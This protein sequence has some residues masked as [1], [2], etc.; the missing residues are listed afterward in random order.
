M[1]SSLT[2]TSA[3]MASSAP[4][5]SAPVL[6]H[7]QRWLLAALVALTAVSWAWLGLGAGMGPM[8]GMAMT[9]PFAAIVLMW[10]VMMA[11]MMIPAAVP[12]I[13]LYARVRRHHGTSVA[14]TWLFVAGYLAVWTAFGIVAAA[15]QSRLNGG[16]MALASPRAAAVLLI[17]AGLYQLSPLKDRC[18]GAC[19]SPASFI[20][21]HSRPGPAGALRLGLLHGL[22]CLGCCWLIMALLFVGGVMNLAWV[23]LLTVAV[24]AEKLL[25]SGQAVAR[26]TGFV[27]LGWGGWLLLP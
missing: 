8:A 24:S 15:V 4:K 18:L 10:S 12:T 13:L 6:R 20:A 11:A 23:A 27:L 3:A 9:P 19:R 14:P 16:A 25:S 21:R 22:F 1:A 7:E 5:Q 17:A 26:A 2:S